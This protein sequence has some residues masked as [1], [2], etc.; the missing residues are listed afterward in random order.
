MASSSFPPTA[1]VPQVKYDV[2]LSFRGEDTR[3]N[4]TSHLYAALCRKKIETFIDN[5]LIRGED[6]SPS[7]LDAIE[8]SKI[9][10]V[11]FSKGYASS[12]WCLE[13]LVKI[14]ECKDK[15]GQ[16]VIPVF[17]HVEPSNVRNQTGI[18]GDAFSMFEERFVGREDKLRTWRIAL[19]EA[20]NISG[21]DSNTVR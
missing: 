12:G 14:L 11:I 5:Q 21:F 4:F 3:D 16:I 6:I 7:L 20:A 17:Y 9:S 8:R 18:F 19:R 2:F 15:Y 13:E 10:V 1:T